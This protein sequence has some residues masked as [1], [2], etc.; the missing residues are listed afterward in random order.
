[1]KKIDWR[2][3]KEH[4]FYLIII[5]ILIIMLVFV[6]NQ[7]DKE[8]IKCN[9]EYQIYIDSHCKTFDNDIYSGD[10]KSLNISSTINI[11]DGRS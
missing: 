10:Y 4:L 7:A 1:M 2:R 9:N 6:G 3:L 8:I 5:A 11:N